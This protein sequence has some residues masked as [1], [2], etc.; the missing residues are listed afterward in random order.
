M[1]WQSGEQLYRPGNTE[2]GLPASH[3]H[4]CTWPRCLYL[5]LAKVSVLVPGQG[6]CTWPRCLYLAKVPVLLP[7]ESA[8]TSIWPR[9]LYLYMAK[10]IVPGQGAEYTCFPKLSMGGVNRIMTIALHWST[11]IFEMRNSIWYS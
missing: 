9:C 7:G 8:C 1:K 5:Y 2:G 4:V 10:L 11:V 6:D 3:P